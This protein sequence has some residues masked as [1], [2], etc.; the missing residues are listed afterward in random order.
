MKEVK[1]DKNY[2]NKKFNKKERYTDRKGEE[3]WQRF[4]C[5]FWWTDL[6][7]ALDSASLLGLNRE[8]P[9]IEKALYWFLSRQGHT[10]L[11]DIK[12]LKD[13]YRDQAY[14]IAL[15]ICRI[16]KRFYS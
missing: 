14:W 11:W 6:L 9:G 5:P 15:A 7:S 4:S 13:H 2:L 8:E 12:L 16:I 3:Y 1:Q 10:G